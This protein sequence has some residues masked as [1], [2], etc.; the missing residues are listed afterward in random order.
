[1]K[2]FKDEVP[3]CTECEGIVKPDIVFFGENLPIRFFD[4]VEN[5]FEECELL[6]VL[7]SSL[8]VQPFASLIDR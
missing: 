4:C 6:L 3:K 1:V 5:D 8:I 7:G 2:I